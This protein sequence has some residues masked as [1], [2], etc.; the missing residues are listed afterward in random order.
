MQGKFFRNLIF[1]VFLNLLIKPFWIFGIDRTVQN[2][3]GSEQYGFYFTLVNFSL[4]FAIFLDV[5]I[6]N[7]NNRN[8]ARDQSMLSRHF[9]KI[10]VLRMFLIV[11][12]ALFL[13]A[14]AF[15]I[16]YS[17]AQIKMLIW[18]GFN[19]LLLTF[20]L[21][22]R[23]NI[24]GLLLLKTDSFLSVLDRLLMIVLCSLL[25]WGNL[26]KASFRIEW[27]VYAQSIS[28]IIT[29]IIAFIIVL[30]NSKW[31]PLKFDWSFIKSI[32]KQSFPFAVLGLLMS[33]Y[34]RTDPVFIERLLGNGIGEEQSGIYAQSFRIFDA[35]NNFSLLFGILLLPIF[36]RMIK[37]RE[38]I[39]ELLKLANSLMVI[40]VISIVSV[41]IFYSDEIID[42]LYTSQVGESESEFANR[43][44]DSSL[45]LQYLI[46]GII[47]V[48]VSYVFG[49]LLTANGNLKRLT[50]IALVGVILNIS[51]NIILIPK[52]QAFGSSIASLSAH[53]ITAFLIIISCIQKFNLKVNF[54]Y[55][56]AI[57]TFILLLIV[58][59]KLSIQIELY[60]I[61]KLIILMVISVVLSFTLKLLNVKLILESIR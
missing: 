5:G 23:S 41:C 21:F 57:F 45:I 14:T 7:F 28:Y 12:Y 19:Q 6:S 43:L 47:G 11:G 27:F 17:E 9:S 52:Y 15:I 10:I 18:V 29:A 37:K 4:I 56:G 2:L 42:L 1:L 53:S 54:K 31:T 46:G 33:F 3:V 38:S 24:S 34:S 32:L 40:F 35:A 39:V 60:W 49:S 58:S 36:S 50:Y 22:L 61:Y 59:S 16:G 55:I 25:I 30:I 13:F 51:L 48:A 8:I 26:M 20:I 44:S